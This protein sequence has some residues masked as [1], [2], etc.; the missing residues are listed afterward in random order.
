[1]PLGSNPTFIQIRDFFGGSNSFRD[2]YRGGPFVPNIPANAGISTTIEGLRQTQ[3]SGADKVGRA[4]TSLSAASGT[5]NSTNSGNASSG[6]TTG[7]VQ[8]YPGGGDGT[9]SW[10]AN[11]LSQTNTASVSPTVN[12]GNVAACTAA[13]TGV[14]VGGQKNATVVVRYTAT[15][16]GTSASVDITFN[17]SWY[18]STAPSCVVTVTKISPV[19]DQRAG[20]LTLQDELWITDPY[21]PVLDVVKGQVRKSETHLQPCVRLEMANGT[22]L[23][24][25]VSAPIPTLDGVYVE[26]MDLLGHRVPTATAAQVV[27]GDVS[28]MEWTMVVS[29]EDIGEREVQLLYVEDRAFWASG[30]GERFVLHHNSKQII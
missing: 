3:F 11:V 19:T 29:V 20:A 7:Q 26:A 17:L 14:G 13:I 27:S 4:P 30:D 2:Y 12:G 6:N 16:I 23:E 24:C 22:W 9:Y 18:N 28:D 5:V 1:M 8:L 21:A 10:G 25:S 15:S